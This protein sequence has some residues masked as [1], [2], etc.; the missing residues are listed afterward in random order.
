MS[1]AMDGRAQD[2]GR[3]YQATG[4]Q[5][6]TE[7]H[8][9]AGSGPAAVGGPDSVRRPAV[10]RTP[11][12]LRDRSEVLARLRDGLTSGRGAEVYVLHGMGGCGKT[13]VAQ[14]FF[15]IATVEYLRVGLWV[16]AADRAGL[17]AAC[18]RPPPTEVPVTAN[19]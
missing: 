16:N 17:R 18:S 19:C 10:G 14:A 5:H 12:A 3:V 15:D 4:D 2:N 6:I 1:G 7:H 8:H 11:L 13:A 9:Y